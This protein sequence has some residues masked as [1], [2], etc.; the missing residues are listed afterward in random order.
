MEKKK[1]THQ[2]S[3]DI[4]AEMIFRTKE[5]YIG[6]GNIMLMWGYLTV[7]VTILVWVLLKPPTILYGIGYGSS[8]G[9][10]V[11]QQHQ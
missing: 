1:L 8:Y 7:A 10:L 4:I 5:R 6:D 11:E 3:I 9:L 2:E